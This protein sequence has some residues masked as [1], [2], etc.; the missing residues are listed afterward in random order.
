LRRKIGVFAVVVAR[1]KVRAVVQKEADHVAARGVVERG[2]KE[3]RLTIRC[4][5]VDLGAVFEKQDHRGV[6]AHVRN[7]VQINRSD[8]RAVR[9]K[10]AHDLDAV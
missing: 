9:Q 5:L 6:M 7:S 2:H 1:V 4:T 10:Y 3:R 8:I